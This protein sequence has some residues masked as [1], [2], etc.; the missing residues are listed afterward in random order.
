MYTAQVVLEDVTVTRIR[1]TL[2]TPFTLFVGTAGTFNPIQ[3]PG[4]NPEGLPWPPQVCWLIGLRTA[5]NTRRGRGRVYLPARFARGPFD[6]VTAFRAMAA[7][8]QVW[9][10]DKTD[11]GHCVATLHAELFEAGASGEYV[12]CVMS[13]VDNASYAVT[14]FAVAD[15]LR[16][17][18]E[19]AFTPTTHTLYGLSGEPA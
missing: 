19:R 8:G 9:S 4:T 7:R 11:L 15:F 10:E 1:P 6:D 3:T 13:E 12:W 2:G 14:H 17:Q 18:R 16:T 5:L